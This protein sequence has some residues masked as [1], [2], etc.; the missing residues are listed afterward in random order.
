LIPIDPALASSLEP[1]TL[2]WELENTTLNAPY[3][4]CT[5]NFGGGN[6]CTDTFDGGAAIQRFYRGQDQ[7]SGPIRT[8]TV[9]NNDGATASAGLGANA[10]AVGTAHSLFATISLAGGAAAGSSDSPIQLRVATSSGSQ[11]AIDCD[12]NVTNFRDQLTL[13]CKPFYTQN[14][15]LS[16]PDPCNPPYGV[17][18]TTLFASPNPPFWQCVGVQTGA[19]IG[20]FTDGILGRVYNGGQLCTGGGCPGCPANTASFVPGRN[21]WTA[22]WAGGTFDVRDDDPR[23]VLLFMVPFGSFRSSGTNFLF[24]I[25]NFGAFYLTGWGGNGGGSDSCPGFDPSVP[26]GWLSGHFVTYKLPSNTGGGKGVG[27][28]DASGTNPC[29]AILTQ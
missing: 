6:K 11:A 5:K 22:D 28:C 1:I 14:T 26:A 25:T 4:A 8:A 19:S 17:N 9:W 12:P 2:A 23:L 10:Y 3:G 7:Y 27:T 29:V 21:Y 18:K 24:P 15:R 20:Q 13:G 16:Q